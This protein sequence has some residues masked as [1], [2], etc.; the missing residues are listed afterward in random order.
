MFDQVRAKLNRFFKSPKH[1]DF[2]DS[3]FA[4]ARGAED[5]PFAKF[6]SLLP[7]TGFDSNYRVFLIEA[8]EAETVESIGFCLSF[9]FQVGASSQM[10]D[11]L[12][13]VFNVGAP[14]E[15]GIQIILNGSPDL[16]DLLDGM[17]NI[18]L[19]P[20]DVRGLGAVKEDQTRL[21]YEMMKKRKEFYERGSRENLFHD[22]SFR[23]RNFKGMFCV[24]IPVSKRNGKF[25]TVDEFYS[26]EGT[27][28]FLES[29]VNIRD[30]ISTSLKNYFLEPEEMGPSELINW[31][32]DLLNIHRIIGGD[33][34]VKDYDSGKEIRDQ[35]V[36]PDTSIRE[37]EADLQ[38]GGAGHTPVYARCMSVRNYP[39][40]MTMH[41]MGEL[42]GSSTNATLAY[43]CP[44]LIVLGVKLLDYDAEKNKTVLKAARA[45]QAAESPMAKLQPD[46]IDRK[47]DWDI[48]QASFDEGKGSV[49]LYHQIILFCKE[50]ELPRA[51]QAAKGIWRAL[52]FDVA[53]DRLMQKQSL[54]A[55]MPMMLGPLMQRDMQIAARITTKTI[56]NAANMMPVIAETTGVGAPVMS[57]FGRRGQHIAVDIFANPSGNYNGVCVGTS[58]SGKSFALN[59]LATGIVSIGGRVWII[60][61]GRSF[62]KLCN[63]LGGQFISFSPNSDIRLN[64]FSLV[65]DI[66]EDMNMLKPMIATMISPNAPLEQYQLAQL[67][68]HIRQLW[69]E[70]GKHTTITMLAERLKKACYNGGSREAFLGEEVDESQCDPRIRD[71]G[72]QLFQFTDEGSFGKYF[73]GEANVEFN[74]DF[75]VLELEELNNQPDLQRV[76]MFIMMYKITQE[77]YLGDRNQRK[78]VIIDEA[79]Q[80]LGGGSGAA[81]SFIEN[82]YRR[83]RKYG[84][85]FWTGTQSVGDYAEGAAKAAFD[86]ADWMF[87]LRQK[88]ESIEA[89]AKTGKLVL[90]DHQRQMLQSVTTRSGV[91]SEIFMRCGDL[92]PMVGRLFVDEFTQ[93]VYSS[94]AEDFRAV[95]ESR[96]TGLSTAQAIDKVLESRKAR[97]AKRA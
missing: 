69:E 55:A 1:E 72:V 36:Y 97:H 49:K 16:S 45:T 68:I 65:V 71:L 57:F 8:D 84:A 79:W 26:D 12:S 89:L 19:K 31:C 85:A 78:V 52:N 44:F 11:F 23:M 3:M 33:R 37:S 27:Q 28:E 94:K 87:M 29:V 83:A 59:S 24:N 62:Q 6:S 30:S 5:L 92:P 21:L 76:I 54:L 86:N 67:E 82:G 66:E 50:K 20:E 75:V 40:M 25:Q 17:E 48:A 81:A 91:F 18:T 22:L 42:I 51:E 38:I 35:I 58:G 61:V 43:P 32:S 60:D 74:S 46:L 9:R 14:P 10:A 39:K 7:Y 77:M 95:E 47:F 4:E 2:S 70:F 63:M 13:N 93:L 64:P 90:D 41:G 73:E 15:T 56:Y 53:T 80:C 34:F 88:K 96:K